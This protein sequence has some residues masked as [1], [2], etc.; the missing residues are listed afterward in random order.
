MYMERFKKFMDAHKSVSDEW[1]VTS[2]TCGKW[3]IPDK[4]LDKFYI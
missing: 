1:N 4:D 2:M 3:Y